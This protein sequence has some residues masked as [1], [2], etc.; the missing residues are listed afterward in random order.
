M[1]SSKLESITPSSLATVTGGVDDGGAAEA[2]QNTQYETGGRIRS[3]RRDRFTTGG[4]IE[5]G[6]PFTTG[7]S[8]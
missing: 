4:T 5:G 8:F 6:G 7:G 1:T 3:G 2:G